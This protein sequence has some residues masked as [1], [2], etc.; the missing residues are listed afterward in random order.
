M[1]YYKLL[2]IRN[3]LRL[4]KDYQKDNRLDFMQ[5][6]KYPEQNQMREMILQR[7][8]VRKGPNIFVVFGGNRSG[9]SE[10]GGGVVASVFKE[11]KDARIWCATLSDI[12]VKVQQRKIKDMVR[13]IDIDYGE[14]N[15]VR[16]WKNKTIT[17]K[18]GSV[19]YFKTYEQGAESFQGDD[20]DL[21]WMD[22]EPP[23]DVFSET[24]IR[25]GDRGGVMVITFTSLMGFTR[26]VNRLWE[27]NDPNIKTTI[28]TPQMNPFLSDEV[29]LQLAGNIDPDE[30]QSRWE[31]KPHLKEG[32]I[33]KEFGAIH[34][35]DRFDYKTLIAQNPQRW[36]LHEGIDPHER[37]PHHWLRFLYDRK[38]DIIYIVEE[39]KAPQESMLIKAF[40]MMIKQNR[41]NLVPDFCQID[42]SSM[43]PDVITVHPDEDQDNVMTVRLEFHNNGI[44]TVLVSKDNAV[45]INAVKERLKTIKTKEGE[46]KRK[47]TMYVFSDLNGVL[48][49]FSRYSWDSYTSTKIAEKKELV[50]NPL[51]KDDH[52]MD[53]I[54]YECLKIKLEIG[55]NVEQKDYKE[56]YGDMGY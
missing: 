33:Y 54:K 2:K 41:G 14:Y 25:L 39:L 12:S 18:Q 7:L 20:I 40:A 21:A 48:W 56:M 9:K 6:E 42:T 52:F 29:K 1:G 16:G 11:L 13:K 49:E 15:E 36:R 23:Y 55:D 32:L 43:K 34:K 17:S 5:W 3:K 44:E 22:E 26:L 30:M 31:G 38:N 10:L 37:T 45:G 47:P 24:L 46:I 28:L 51:K 19:L 4:L 27:S 50:N 35:I 53:I 8:K